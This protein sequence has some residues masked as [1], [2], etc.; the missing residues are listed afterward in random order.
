MNPLRC[1]SCDKVLP[2]SDV[3]LETGLARCVKCDQVFDVGRAG[4][5]SPEVG[6]PDKVREWDFAGRV[7]WTWSWFTPGAFFLLVFTIA[8]D[9]FLVVWHSATLSML[10][11]GDVGQAGFS[12]FASVFSLPHTLI[13]IVLPY[14]TLSLFVNRTTVSLS[15]SELRSSHGPLWWPGGRR[16]VASEV[17][18]VHGHS[19]TRARGRTMHGLLVKTTGGTEHRFLTGVADPVVATYVGQAL[20]KRLRIPF[21]DLW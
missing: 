8:W 2:S 12:L 5:T 19:Q 14:Y 1:P 18:E 13:G 10:F 7:S 17:A 15:G 9:S 6:R 3:H 4:A 16:L 21:H 20:A 11:A